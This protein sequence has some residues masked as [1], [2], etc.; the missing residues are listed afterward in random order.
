[1]SMDLNDIRSFVTLASLALFA[2]LVAWTWWPGRKPAH[3][4]AAR[5]PFEGESEQ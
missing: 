1:M 5:L 4:T 3:E 2:G